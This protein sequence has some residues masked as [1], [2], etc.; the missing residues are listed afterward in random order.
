MRSCLRRSKLEL[1]DPETTSTMMRKTL[2]RYILRR[3]FAQMPNLPGKLAGGCA[4]G[5]CQRGSR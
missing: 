4:G 1:H 5:A 2:E 3:L